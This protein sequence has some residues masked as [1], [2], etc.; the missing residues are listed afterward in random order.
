MTLHTPD[1]LAQQIQDYI[2]LTDLLGIPRND[3]K[4]EL[5]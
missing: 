3:K 2:A 1:Y 5:G 4:D